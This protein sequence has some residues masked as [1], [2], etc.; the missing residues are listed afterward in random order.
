MA[1]NALEP[2]RTKI[3]MTGLLLGVGL[4]LVVILFVNLVPDKPIVTR[5]AAAAVLM[6]TWWLFE[7]Y[8]FLPRP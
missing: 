8:R 5:M 3:Q 2:G 4:F 1:G 7:A 6:A